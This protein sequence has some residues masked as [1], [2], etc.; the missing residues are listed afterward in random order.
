ML[1][2]MGNE[3]ALFQEALSICLGNWVFIQPLMVILD[4][5]KNGFNDV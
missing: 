5:S 2:R 4:V 3:K 1:R